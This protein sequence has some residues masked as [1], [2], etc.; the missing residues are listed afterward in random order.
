MDC[1][2]WFTVYIWIATDFINQVLLEYSSHVCNVFSMANITVQIQRSFC[3]P[4]CKH[5]LPGCLFK[6]FQLTDYELLIL[7]CTVGELEAQGVLS[8]VPILF[9]DTI[10]KAKVA[11]VLYWHNLYFVSGQAIRKVN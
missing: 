1:K 11:E 10:F 4:S 2:L 6:V 8:V 7:K 3:P 5:L 9:M